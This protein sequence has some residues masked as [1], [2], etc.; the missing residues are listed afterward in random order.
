M[1]D[2]R[3]PGEETPPRVGWIVLRAFLISVAIGFVVTLVYIV[4]R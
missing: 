4:L 3:R 1:S 2:E